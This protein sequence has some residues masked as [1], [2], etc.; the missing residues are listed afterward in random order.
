MAV[1]HWPIEIGKNIRRYI[2][3]LKFSQTVLET[4]VHQVKEML[5]KFQQLSP[6]DSEFEPTI[7]KLM[8]D[9]AEHIKEEESEDLVKLE[10]A[11]PNSESHT[12]AASFKRTKM[13][14]PTRSHP[15]APDK[16]VSISELQSWLQLVC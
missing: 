7:K 15:S 16:P 4:N 14:V 6:S 10:Q 8:S 2:L 12:L 9:L 1:R 11:V 5:H 13:F 3:Y